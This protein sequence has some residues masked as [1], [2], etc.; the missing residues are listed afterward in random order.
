MNTTNKF[1]AHLPTTTP[2]SAQRTTASHAPALGCRRLSATQSSQPNPLISAEG[3]STGTSMSVMLTSGSAEQQQQ[4]QESTQ[5]VGTER[6]YLAGLENNF[7]HENT[8]TITR[9]VLTAAA[10]EYMNG[11]GSSIS[12]QQHEGSLSA[13][14]VVKASCMHSQGG[15]QPSDEGT[16]IILNENSNDE[17]G[18]GRE[19]AVT[20]VSFDPVS[21]EV[22]H[23]VDLSHVLQLNNTALIPQVGDAVR[24]KVNTR[25]REQ[26]SACHSAGH[27]VDRAMVDVG[28]GAFTP[29]K[30]YHFLD[31]PYVEYKGNIPPPERPDTV[32][33]LAKAFEELVKA[34]MLT[35]IMHQVLSSL[36]F[37]LPL[38]YCIFVTNS[39]S[40]YLSISP[41]SSLLLSAVKTKR[42]LSVIALRC[43]RMFQTLLLMSLLMMKR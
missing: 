29:H 9:V 4:Q 15:G 8:S 34:D 36:P 28:L 21:K 25:K 13:E 40:L 3:K 6:L 27:A 14:I 30:A 43:N 31:S 19:F 33:K 7:L 35:E 32:L 42:K 26:Y 11:I 39:L 22:A 38:M 16:L 41:F 17:E 10:K 24:L 5:E 1:A 18:V 2:S 20:S 23:H 37:H 12:A